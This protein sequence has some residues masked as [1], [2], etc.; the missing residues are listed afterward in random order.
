M[1]SEGTKELQKR[2]EKSKSISDL[3]DVFEKSCLYLRDKIDPISYHERVIDCEIAETDRTSGL[4]APY[5]TR[6][7]VSLTK[8]LDVE[9][10]KEGQYSIFFWVNVTAKQTL[11]LV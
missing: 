7:L 5:F 4:L 3:L 9:N 10:K 8:Y 6:S 2:F 11:K 1:R